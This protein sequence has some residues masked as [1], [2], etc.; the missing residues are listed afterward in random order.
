MLRICI[1]VV[2]TL[3][4]DVKRNKIFKHHNSK[5]YIKFIINRRGYH[6]TK[7]RNCKLYTLQST[8]QHIIDTNA[9]TRRYIGRGQAE[10]VKE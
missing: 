6:N 7:T 10:N 9:F 1:F 5:Q 8:R 3:M 4:I 2:W